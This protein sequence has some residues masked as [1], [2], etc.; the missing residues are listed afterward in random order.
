MLIKAPLLAFFT[1][2]ATKAGS[3]AWDALAGFVAKVYAE[4]R[5]WG[6]PEGTIWLEDEDGPRTVILTDRVPDA[7]YEQLAAGELPEA[8]HF[9]WDEETSSWRA[10]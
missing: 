8:G 1:A 6:R 5:R 4:R 7:G 9:V 2:L 10:Y 3:D